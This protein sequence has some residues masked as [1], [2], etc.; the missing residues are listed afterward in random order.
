M[1]SHPSAVVPPQRRRRRRRTARVGVAVALL[2]GL[3][4]L[5]GM[6][7]AVPAQASPL[8]TTS[9]SSTPDPNALTAGQALAQAKQTGTPVIA[10]GLTNPVGQTTANPNG[11]LTLTQ[12]NKPVRA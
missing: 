7:T 8:R 4:L 1:P 12:S 5:A 9:A 6:A 2:A 10:T 11:T 3:G